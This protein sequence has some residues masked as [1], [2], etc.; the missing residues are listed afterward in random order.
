M[1][2][3]QLS[4]AFNIV[5]IDE[6][7]YFLDITWLAESL[8]SGEI[9]SLVNSPYFLPSNE[10]FEHDIYKSIL[11]NYCCTTMDREKVR[12]SLKR[13]TSWKEKYVIHPQALKD[14]FR[15]HF[16]KNK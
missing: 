3:G 12:S 1:H 9:K 2:P 10:D 4:H 6:E 16:I 7:E 8:R 15:K 5:R 11:D 13:V 14:L